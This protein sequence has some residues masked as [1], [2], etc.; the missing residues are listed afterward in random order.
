MRKIRNST[1]VVS[2][3]ASVTNCL[4]Y[5]VSAI[6]T[7]AS[8]PGRIVQQCS[9]TSVTKGRGMCYPVCGMVHIREP[10]LL[11]DKSSPCGD[12]AFLSGYQNGPFPY[13]RR[14]ITV[15]KMCSVRL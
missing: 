9:T 4:Y 6:T 2:H 3:L 11:I 13:V 5:G 10:L 8:Q 7:R 15:N 12:R 14:H 1:P